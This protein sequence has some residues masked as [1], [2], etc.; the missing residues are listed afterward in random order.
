MFD[1]MGLDIRNVESRQ[2][3][4]VILV[5]Y[6]NHLIEVKIQFVDSLATWVWH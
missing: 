3:Q 2:I 5:Y 1:E 4:K 6:K